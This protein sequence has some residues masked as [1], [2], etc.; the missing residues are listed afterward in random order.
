[1]KTF[2]IHVADHTDRD[3]NVIKLASDYEE[4]TIIRGIVPEWVEDLYNRSVLGCSLTHLSILEKYID[5]DHILILEDDAT[6]IKDNIDKITKSKI[7]DDAGIILVGGD[8]VPNYSHT[9]FKD[10]IYHEVYPPFFGTQAVWYN[11]CELRKTNFLVN[12]YRSLATLPVGRGGIC[13]ESVL[14]QGLNNTGLKIFRPVG[15]LYST[16]PSRSSRDQTITTPNTDT[17]SIV[18]DK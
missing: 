17:I 9:A 6:I 1:M 3:L 13:Y 8:N 7:P 18:N 14:A 11:M 15:M 5:I 4:V 2:I 10:T 12:A 16:I